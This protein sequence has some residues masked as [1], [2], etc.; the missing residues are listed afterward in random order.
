MTPWR[1]VSTPQSITVVPSARDGVLTLLITI[2]G[3]VGMYW[4]VNHALEIEDKTGLMLAN[5]ICVSTPLLMALVM[6]VWWKFR[7]KRPHLLIDL[8]ANAVS[9]PRSGLEFPI[10]SPD[11]VFVYD[12]ISARGDDT[13]CEFNLLL[14]RG[15]GTTTH[16]IFHNLGRCTAYSKLGRT[17]QATGLRFESRKSG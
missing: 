3:G 1:V 9:L 2:I 10:Q 12:T 5:F 6:G 11:A 14:G 4:L 16:P 7:D 13:V 15:E 8:R 17:L